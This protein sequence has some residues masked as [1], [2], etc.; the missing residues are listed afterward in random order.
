MYTLY[1]IKMMLNNKTLQV[2]KE[3][4]KQAPLFCVKVSKITYYN[5]YNAHFS[6]FLFKVSMID[7]ML[8]SVTRSMKTN[9]TYNK[10]NHLTTN[11]INTVSSRMI[12]YTH[13]V[14]LSE[15][16][17]PDRSVRIATV[18]PLNRTSTKNTDPPRHLNVNISLKVLSVNQSHDI[19]SH[20]FK[21]HDFSLSFSEI[22]IILTSLLYYHST[23]LVL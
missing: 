10:T 11:Q 9:V 5:C 2:K 7:T 20:G 15:F 16:I 13:N 21:Q 4:I 23:F 19:V 18:E 22:L 3:K 8:P 6:S 1:C 14:Q 12:I 17:C